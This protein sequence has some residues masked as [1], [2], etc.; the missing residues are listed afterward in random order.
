MKPLSADQAESTIYGSVKATK[1]IYDDDLLLFFGPDCQLSNFYPCKLK[2]PEF[3][4]LKFHSVEQAMMFSKA[5]LFDD[6][7]AMELIINSRSPLACKRAGRQVKNFD[8]GLWQ[9]MRFSVVF[10]YTLQKFFSDSALLTV[11]LATR[12]YMLVESTRNDFIW[13]CGYSLNDLESRNPDKWGLNLQGNVLTE[14]RRLLDPMNHIP[15]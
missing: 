12:G 6:L 13:G 7:D 11:L 15:F 10:N 14:V 3:T 4:S 1:T 9:F 8:D 5:A 2:H